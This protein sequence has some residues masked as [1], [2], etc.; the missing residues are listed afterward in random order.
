M[1]IGEL[2]RYLL[3]TIRLWYTF[4]F[5]ARCFVNLFVRAI[6]MPNG[7]FFFAPSEI[8]LPH[9]VYKESN[10]IQGTTSYPLLHSTVGEC[11]KG[12]SSGLLRPL[13]INWCLPLPPL[14]LC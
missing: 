7:H 2:S 12:K 14:R 10:V 11:T 1:K 5:E 6:Q 13:V 8:I 3:N 9:Y 4:Y